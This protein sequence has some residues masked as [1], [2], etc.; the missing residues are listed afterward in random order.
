MLPGRSLWQQVRKP[1]QTETGESWQL[2]SYV[3]NV[4]YITIQWD[5]VRSGVADLRAE[6]K[7]TFVSCLQAA[8]LQVIGNRGSY[9]VD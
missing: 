8:C 5:G 4:L 3:H 2:A 7:S 1:L 6:H 9:E